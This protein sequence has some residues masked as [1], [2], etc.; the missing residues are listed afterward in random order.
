MH[1]FIELAKEE[2]PQLEYAIKKIDSFLNKA[3]EGS[4]KWQ[5]NGKQNTPLDIKVVKQLVEEVVCFTY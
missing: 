4:L 1:K 2:M 3:P 5:K